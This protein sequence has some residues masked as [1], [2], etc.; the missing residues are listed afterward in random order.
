[1]MGK[2]LGAGQLLELLVEPGAH[3]TFLASPAGEGAG[4][5]QTPRS[6]SKGNR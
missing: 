3:L 5:L 6:L 4:S 2:A 1:M